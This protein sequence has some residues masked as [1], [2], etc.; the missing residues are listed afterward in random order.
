MKS[1]PPKTVLTIT[2]GFL[3]VYYI[4]KMPWAIAVAVIIGGLGLLSTTIA[5]KI[6]W[7]W[8]KLT[9]LLSLIVPNILLSVLFF[10]FLFPVAI[11]TRL[12]GKKN[13]LQ[14]KQPEQTTWIKDA[15]AFN[16]QSMENPW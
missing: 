15:K 14:L 5:Q 16:P 4:T 9:W 7:L 12:L 11:L 1:N 3:V 2:V 10:L 13:L 8:M 6:E